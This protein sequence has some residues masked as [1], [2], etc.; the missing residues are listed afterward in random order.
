MGAF[1]SLESHPKIQTIGQ[2][3]RFYQMRDPYCMAAMPGVNQQF[4][5]YKGGWKVPQ[6]Q[7][8]IKH[9]IYFLKAM[10]RIVYQ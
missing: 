8:L 3:L 7:K 5:H 9:S 1:V 6:K 4:R 2:P 10:L